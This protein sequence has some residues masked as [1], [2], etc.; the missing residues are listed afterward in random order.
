MGP[1]SCYKLLIYRINHRAKWYANFAANISTVTAET[2]RSPDSSK[3]QQNAARWSC[4]N[5]CIFP[6]VWKTHLG[7]DHNSSPRSPK[8][9][10]APSGEVTMRRCL[11]YTLRHTDGII[12]A[13]V[14]APIW[15]GFRISSCIS[16]ETSVFR[17][18]IVSFV[19]V[20][21]HPW[22]DNSC[23]LY[24]WTEGKQNSLDKRF[25]L[26]AFIG[27]YMTQHISLLQ[28]RV[29]PA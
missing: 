4:C 9:V 19:F 22:V 26:Y 28:F 15:Y 12:S 18:S 14:A 17:Q 13:Y 1:V 11:S 3:A 21:V 2:T 7:N 10:K 6:Y 24:S 27:D 29:H 16:T 25:S 8:T 5:L 20:S 23:I